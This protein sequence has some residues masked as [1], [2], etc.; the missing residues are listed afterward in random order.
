[1]RR[2]PRLSGETRIALVRL[3]RGSLGA[4]DQTPLSASSGAEAR[5]ALSR[6]IEHHVGGRLP[7]RKFLDEVGPLL[8]H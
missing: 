2:A 4:A 3:Q 6:F 8:G 7:S 5:D 1:M